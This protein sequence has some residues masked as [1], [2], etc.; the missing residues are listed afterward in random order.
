MSE[1]TNFRPLAVILDMDGLILETE[2]PE[3]P[4]WAKAGKSLGLNV[5]EETCLRTIGKTGADIR[6]LVMEEYG[7]NFPY[8]AFHVELHRLLNEEFE[9]GIALRPGL[10]ILL[11]S[12][13]AAKI[14]YAIATSSY[15]ENALWKL[16]KAGILDR[17]PLLVGGDEVQNGKPAPDIFLKAANLLGVAP[18]KCIGFEDSA[19][20]L[21]GLQTA[22]IRSVFVKD[23]VTP[24]EEVLNKV[25]RQYGDLA[26]AARDI[27]H[28]SL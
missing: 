2:R 1:Q 24:P 5:K 12:L 21:K 16:E 13:V 23:I 25:W 8:D 15:R 3:I 10:I 6:K 17:F 14:P 18:D 22:G 28:V 20:G 26:E 19:A 11:D 7:E 9:S 4:L 27:F